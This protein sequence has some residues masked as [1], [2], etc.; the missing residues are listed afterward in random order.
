[1]LV[2]DNRR[3]MPEHLS[4]HL[5]SGRLVPRI[6]L[7]AESAGLAETVERLH[8]TASASHPDEHQDQIKCLTGL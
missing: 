7:L 2:T 6:L 1:M 4:A 8:L 5:S 3:T